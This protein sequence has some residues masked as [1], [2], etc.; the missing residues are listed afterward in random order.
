MI[1]RYEIEPG[2]IGWMIIDTHTGRPACVK[3]VPQIFLPFEDAD[4][5]ADCL[6]DLHAEQLSATLH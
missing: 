1:A 3:A 2:V 6:N 4:D 5:L